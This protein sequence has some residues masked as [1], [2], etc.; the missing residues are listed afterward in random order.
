MFVRLSGL[1]PHIKADLS[2]QHGR[3]K[4]DLQLLA[5]NAFFC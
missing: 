1:Q 2:W 4:Q 3:L 5:L